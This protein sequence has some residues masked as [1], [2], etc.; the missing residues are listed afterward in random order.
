MTFVCDAIQPQAYKLSAMIKGRRPGTT[1]LAPIVPVPLGFER[2]LLVQ[3]R[4]VNQSVAEGLRDI[5]IPRYK[6]KLVTDADEDSFNALRLLVGAM[7][8]AASEQVAQL[9]NLEGRRHTKAWMAAARRAFG[10]DLSSVVSE[11]DLETFL[12]AAALRNASLIRG[13]AE[14]ILKRVA[15]ETT[16]ALI[17]GESA[18]QLQVRL[19]KQLG[20]GDNRA[21]LIARDQTS[22]LTS[23]L[24]RIR[25]EQAGITKYIWRTSVDERV[26][27]R[28]RDLEGKVYEYGEPTGAEEGLPPGQ[29]IQ[30]RCIAQAV[31]EFGDVEM[32]ERVNSAPEVIEENSVADVKKSWAKLERI[33][34]QYVQAPNQFYA[35]PDLSTIMEK[36]VKFS[37]KDAAFIEGVEGNCHWN[38]ARLFK[39]GEVDAVVVGYAENEAGWFQHTWGMKEGKVVETNPSALEYGM[40]NYF[41]VPLDKKTSGE[42]ADFVLKPDNAPGNGNVR[43]VKGGRRWVK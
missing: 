35:D 7:I 16:A 18:A 41:G 14:D 15:T 4:R 6:T 1:A 43:T 13:M 37:V 32:P 17:A 20:I 28:H 5:I 23:D 39:T 31:I 8:R 27:P 9:L 29:P 22:K 12:S 11:E 42:F 19:K 33:G 10:I 36:A 38:A 40:S 21:R 30:C 25:H 26:R 34:D 24:N 3:L 2:S